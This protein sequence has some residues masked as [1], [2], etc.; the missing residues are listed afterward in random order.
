MKTYGLKVF[1]PS[2]LA[3]GGQI[4]QNIGGVDQFRRIRVGFV[5]SI[6]GVDKRMFRIQFIFILHGSGSSLKPECVSGSRKPSKSDP[7]RLFRNFDLDL[8]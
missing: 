6:H 7:G 1:D 3:N 2:P 5:K 4:G 8:V